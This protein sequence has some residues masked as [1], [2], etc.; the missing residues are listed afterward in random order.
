MHL[1][2][3]VLMKSSLPRYFLPVGGRGLKMACVL[4]A[5]AV[6]PL[7]ASA[8]EAIFPLEDVRPGQE[9]VWRTVVEG[10]EIRE[11]PLRILG[12]VQDFIG[13]RQPGIIA[14]ALDAENVLSGPVGGMSGSP[15][16]IDGKLVGAY[17]YGYTWPK[18]QAIIGITPIDQM[19]SL[20]DFP[21]EA[22]AALRRVPG[23]AAQRTQPLKE[24]DWLQANGMEEGLV[25][26]PTPL[27]LSGFSGR[28]LET[29]RDELSKQGFSGAISPIGQR[30][31]VELK[32]RPGA[33][34][35]GVL[36]SGDFNAA[37]TGTITWVD[38]DR[39][40][41]FGHPFLQA[42][43]VAMPMAGAEI[44]T[45]VRSVQRSFKL[46]NVGLPVGR[47]VQD[48]LPGIV[49]IRGEPPP[50]AR[51][52]IHVGGEDRNEDQFSADIWPHPNLIPIMLAMATMQSM[53]DSISGEDRLTI[54]MRG[55]LI[56]AEGEKIPLH[57]LATGPGAVRSIAIDVLEQVGRLVSNPFAPLTIDE[58]RISVEMATGWNATA[59]REVIVGDARP[60]AGAT[61][62]VTLSLFEHWGEWRSVS[63]EVPLPERARRGD[64]FDLLV[65]GARE[66]NQ[67]LGTGRPAS[68]AESLDAW[69]APLRE[70]LPDGAIYV[71]LVASGEGG[72]EMSGQRLQHLPPS[73]SATLGNPATR[74]VESR[75]QPRVFWQ[76]S[77]PL[78]G[79]FSGSDRLTLVLE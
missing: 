50:M 72:R 56:F 65:L 70:T 10:D 53:E 76:T 28:T 4:L 20:L 9:G 12:V 25:R 46:A 58:A 19:L 35:A 24:A 41:G 31:N 8:T 42:G 73:V 45:V 62:P 34:V 2:K 38:G 3:G 64:R 49:G 15:V 16:Y 5:G 77:I 26:L 37:A 67:L 1:F 66:A 68:S 52:S 11:F 75:I 27:S 48:R 71:F 23:L 36:M 14:E 55:D 39:F 33:P 32:L 43:S 79:T 17:A 60:R 44:V 59:L 18:E 21:D 47:I 51:L 69:L 22:P 6:I 7:M 78:E 40:I 13:P 61:L 57:S 29:F 74:F 30:E 54:R 63:L